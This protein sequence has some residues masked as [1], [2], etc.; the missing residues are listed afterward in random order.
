[1]KKL[2]E[3]TLRKDTTVAKV[4][5]DKEWFYSVK[6]VADYLGEDLTGVEYIQLPVVIDG[7]TYTMKC[8]AWDDILRVVQKEPLEDFRTSV[9]FNRNAKGKK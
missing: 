1:M 4:Q 8:A 6:D 3:E 9:L 2:K 5:F 7:I